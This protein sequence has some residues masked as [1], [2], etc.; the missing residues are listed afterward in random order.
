MT[1][2]IVPL[3]G[4]R[5]RLKA[6]QAQRLRQLVLEFQDIEP[7]A[8]GRLLVAIDREVRPET[9]WAFVLLNVERN[10]FVLAELSERSA[11]PHVAV[12]VWS[13]LPLYLRHDTN[14]LLVTRDQLAQDVGADKSHV[15]NVL[16][17]LAAMNAILRERDESDR[18]RFRLVLNALVG[19]HTTGMTRALLQQ[20]APELRPLPKRRARMARAK[21]AL[22]VVDPAGR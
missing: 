5:R 6:E 18:R 7:E 14:E 3:G 10:A 12:K 22:R 16:Q 2:T 4:R 19:T 15:S 13:R 21:P 8:A 1:G 20:K 9:E 11:R 17:E